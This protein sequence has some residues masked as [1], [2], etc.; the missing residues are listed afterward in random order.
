MKKNFISKMISV[1]IAL[2]IPV[3]IALPSHAE[4]FLD[5]GVRRNLEVV[6]TFQTGNNY[7]RGMFSLKQTAPTALTAAA[8][9]TTAQ[10]LGGLITLTQATG[11]T[12]A[13]TTPTGAQIQKALPVTFAVNDSFDFTIINLSAAAADTGTLTAG[14]SGVSIVGAVIVPSAHSTTIA[15]SSKTYRVR[16]TAANTFIIYALN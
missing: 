2:V 14:A 6:N 3:S 7:Q 5:V 13:I 15:D 9:L 8:T 12:V 16:K 11:A 4:D 1:M 10:M